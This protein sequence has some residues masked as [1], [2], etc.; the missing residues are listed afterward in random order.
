MKQNL[1]VLL[2]YVAG[3]LC[4]LAGSLLSLIQAVKR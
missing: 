2:L 4:F 3:S 1:L